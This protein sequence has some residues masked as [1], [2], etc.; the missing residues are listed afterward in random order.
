MFCF[1]KLIQTQLSKDLISW[2]DLSIVLTRGSRMGK[3][4]FVG[5]SYE[6]RIRDVVSSKRFRDS[7]LQLIKVPAG[8]TSCWEYRMSLCSPVLPPCLQKPPTPPHPTADTSAIFHGGLGGVVQCDSRTC[9][10]YITE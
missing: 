10:G 1:P 6:P 4:A 5:H 2:N 7:S 3:M 9:F 8:L